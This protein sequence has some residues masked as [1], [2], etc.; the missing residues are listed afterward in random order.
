MMNNL[1]ISGT[2]IK[3][4][5]F[6]I[7][8]QL[9]RRADVASWID[10]D[11]ESSISIDVTRTVMLIIAVRWH[12]GAIKESSAGFGRKSPIQIKQ[13]FRCRTTMKRAWRKCMHLR[14]KAEECRT[15]LAHTTAARCGI[16][17]ATA[18]QTPTEN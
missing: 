2:K 4:R 10:A 9:G 12:L 1:E 18:M 11:E 5:T 7:A 16:C 17:D 14:D 13:Q 8:V 6:A 15:T 3:I